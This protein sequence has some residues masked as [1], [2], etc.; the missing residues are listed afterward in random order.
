MEHL[1]E[2]WTAALIHASHHCLP[3]DYWKTSLTSVIAQ[4]H[5]ELQKASSTQNQLSSQTS[6]CPAPTAGDNIIAI[7]RR[8]GGDYRAAFRHNVFYQR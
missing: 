2:D 3:L 7:N 1:G 5:S 8:T 4:L 6:V